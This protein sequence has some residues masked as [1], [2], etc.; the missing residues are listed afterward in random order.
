[1]KDK[2]EEL[3]RLVRNIYKVLMTRGMRGCY[4]YFEDKELEKYFMNRLLLTN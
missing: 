1:M 4:V 3:N 2:P